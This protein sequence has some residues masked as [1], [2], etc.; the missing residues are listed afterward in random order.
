MICLPQECWSDRSSLLHL[1]LVR[2]LLRLHSLFLQ[3]ASFAADTRPHQMIDIAESTD[4][5]Q[6]HLCIS[7]ILVHYI[8]KTCTWDLVLWKF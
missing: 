4:N 8:T 7:L 2:S 3:F 6:Y 5:R 1:L